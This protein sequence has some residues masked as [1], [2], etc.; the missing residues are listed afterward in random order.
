MRTLRLPFILLVAGVAV[1]LYLVY[2]VVVP[3]NTV[4]IPS[5]GGTY[6]EG[7][8]GAP[9]HINPLLCQPAAVEADLCA[10]VFRGLTRLDPSGEV[11]P[12]LAEISADSPVSYTARLRPDARWEDGVP[13]TSDDVIFTVGLMQDQNFPGDPNLRR[14]WQNVRIER[15]D[16]GTVRFALG[17]PFARFLDFTTV[18]L[19]PRHILSGTVAADLARIPFNLQPRGNGPWRVVEVATASGRVSAVTLEPSPVLEGTPPQMA[20]LVLRYYPDTTAMFDAWRARDLDGMAGLTAADAD[21][22]NALGDATLYAMA[23]ARVVMFVPNLRR[24]SGA[25]AL[26]ETPVRQALMYALDREALVREALGGRAVLA[27]TPFIPDSWA[28]SPDT[29]VYARDLDRA[30]ELLRSAGYELRAASTSAEQVWQKDGEPIGFTLTTPDTA[31]MRAVAELAARQW[32]ELG[33]QVTVQPVRNLQRGSLQPRQFQMALVELLLDGD[34][35]PYSL[36][37]GSQSLQGKNFTGWDNSTANDLLA[38]AR[39]TNDRG[40]RTERYAEFQRLF[41]D[42][43]PALPLFYPTYQYAVARR[44]V[45]VQVGAIVYPSD[46]LRYLGPWQI[47]TRRV[48]PAE[49]TAEAGP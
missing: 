20:R 46:R 24:D 27:N 5:A 49:A 39:E 47:S 9:Q 19:L 48:L 36:W 4:L 14:L 2:Q 25:F 44:V 29:R 3:R 11:I 32:R 43:L 6:T 38:R 12:D 15:V 34:P 23:Q 40:Q 13:V 30:R 18:G 35:D 10:L 31:S 21:R 17:Q 1:I 26:S 41:A 22:V 16:S 37:H 33:V 8:V 45:N 7:V 28:F 42:E